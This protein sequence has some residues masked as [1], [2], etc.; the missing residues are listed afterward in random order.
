MNYADQRIVASFNEGVGLGLLDEYSL[1]I[2][3][4]FGQ[5]L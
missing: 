3:Q 2:S 5:F 1:A 4:S